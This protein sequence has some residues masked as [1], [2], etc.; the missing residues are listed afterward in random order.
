MFI[1]P[2]LAHAVADTDLTSMA[3]SIATTAKEN[4]LAVLTGN[5]PTLIIIGLSILAVFFIWRLIKK[6]VGGR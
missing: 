6:F 2:Y 1:L 5:V 4:M 3:S